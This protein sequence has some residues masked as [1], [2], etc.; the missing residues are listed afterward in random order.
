MSRA[1]LMEEVDADEL[2]DWVAFEMTQDAELKNNLL[3]QISQENFTDAE[4]E[5]LAIKKL[6]MG[7]G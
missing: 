4:K 7:L 1:Q 3:E 5:G 6:L 2:L